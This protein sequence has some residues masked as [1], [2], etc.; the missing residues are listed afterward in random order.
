MLLFF[1]RKNVPLSFCLEINRR[2]HV[3]FIILA[4]L[5]KVFAVLGNQDFFFIQTTMVGAFSLTS[6]N[7]F[8]VWHPYETRSTSALKRQNLCRL[9]AM[10]GLHTPTTCCFISL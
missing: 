6:K 9:I 3:L 8:S 5:F 10:L 2:H 7:K 1:A 4:Y